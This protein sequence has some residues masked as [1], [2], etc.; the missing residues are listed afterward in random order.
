MNKSCCDIKNPLIRNGTSQP[1]RFNSALEPSSVKID[2][3]T[4]ADTI[5]FAYNYADLV[6]F[7]DRDNKSRST[8]HDFFALSDTVMLA[9]ISVTAY[10]S[11][12]TDMRVL[13]KN[14]NDKKTI[15]N[16][17]AI[18]KA[19]H[20]IA[21]EI[22]QW[23]SKIP[24]SSALYPIMALEI[25]KQLAGALKKLASFEKS[26]TIKNSYTL[27]FSHPWGDFDQATFD[28]LAA[29]AISGVDDLRQLFLSF[30]TSY[31]KLIHQS[32]I[33]LEKSLLVKNSHPPHIT[34]F[35]TFLH[36]LQHAKDHLNSFT[37]RHLDFY[38]KEVLRLQKREQVPDLVHVVFELAKNH[39]AYALPKGTALNAGKD[40]AG[41]PLTYKL[42]DE[43]VVNK[44]TVGSLQSVFVDTAD[45]YR[46]Y[47]AT[48]SNSAD[49]LGSAFD[50]S[51]DG[52]WKA[53]GDANLSQA[54]L[55]LAIA[56]PELYVKEGERTIQVEL[57]LFKSI[58]LKALGFTKNASGSYFKA[59]SALKDYF[60]VALSSEEAWLKVLPENLS[61]SVSG[62]G[63]KTI[64]FTVSL[65]SE[66]PSVVPFNSSHLDGGFETSWPVMKIELTSDQD[67]YAYGMLQ[68]NTIKTID[69][70][71]RAKGVRDL[72]IQNDFTLFAKDKAFQ[73]F[74]PNPTLGSNFYI[75]SSEVFSKKLSSCSI[76]FDWL[77]L[78]E[79]GSFE[80][81]YDVYNDVLDTKITNESFT[82]KVS[83]L[84][85]K[86]WVDIFSKDPSLFSV[87]SQEYDLL[88]YLRKVLKS[89]K[90]DKHQ[91]IKIIEGLFKKGLISDKETEELI[92]LIRKNYKSGSLNEIKDYLFKILEEKDLGDSK[93]V[94]EEKKEKDKEGHSSG[95]K[96]GSDLPEGR[97]RYLDEF[98][99]PELHEYVDEAELSNITTISFDSS[100]LSSYKRYEGILDI[101]NYNSATQRGFLQLK[102]SG[103]D[104][105]H[106]KYAEVY[107]KQAVTL[108]DDPDA[109]PAP[110]FPNAPYTPTINGIYLDYTSSETI[111]LQA[112]SSKADYEERVEQVFH[113]YPFGHKEIHHYL[114]GDSV[115]L[116]P[117]FTVD[118]TL[119]FGNFYIG[120]QEANPLESVSLLFQVYEGSGDPEKEVPEITW[121]YL[122]DNSWQPFSRSDII[123]DT[124][125][126]LLKSGVIKF[127]LPADI[128]DSNSLHDTASL[129]IRG[130][131]SKNVEALPDLI[132]VQAQVGIAQ[133]KENNNSVTHLASAL[134]AE[135]IGKLVNSAAGIKGVAQPYAS[136]EGKTVEKDNNF[137][138]RISE[139]LRHKNRAITL[140]DYERLILEEFPSI[141]RVKCISHSNMSTEIAP[142]YV[143]VVVI[144]D[145]RNKNAVNVLEPKVDV[146]T[147][148]DIK[149]FLSERSSLFVQGDDN[150]LLVVNP[151]FEQLKVTASV[152]VSA[153]D[154]QYYLKVLND[155]L[156]KF[157]APWAFDE[158]RDI[159]FGSSLHKSVILNFVE[160]RPYIDFISRISLTHYK[161]G[162]CLGMKNEIAT[163][164]ARSILTS[165]GLTDKDGFE[166][167]ITAYSEES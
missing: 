146:G 77:D 96:K 39:K 50:E 130:V 153:D 116:L 119:A 151:L 95:K 33:L 10:K 145:L 84:D 15:T 16:A 136:F 37:Q 62:V 76:V 105:M 134:P 36:L 143:M 17:R 110:E 89:N 26:L 124:T 30:F 111:D 73:P 86:Q 129:W 114:E 104:F 99:I 166:H 100:T 69:I 5:A 60:N 20:A 103:S 132:D 59:G 47:V 164:S 78:P 156:K 144:P 38:Y 72:I 122:V 157:L 107:T 165:Y 74:G 85:N 93:G 94:E 167:T 34:L 109:N 98:D 125:K 137:Y 154:T 27:F 88:Y 55:G 131:V 81:Y 92:K 158:G 66:D 6:K 14:Y 63:E 142:G 71:V 148:Q 68:G 140:W 141:H 120:L 160:K 128:S 155:D 3:H 40:D 75:G 82:V 52:N 23:N 53:F 64:S 21:G 112:N 162:S 138:R 42:T 118:K 133:F 163:T 117:Q 44:T 161:Q 108:A 13:L 7:Y 18:I 139:R 149:D 2:E 43:L 8:W 113:L 127:A 29:T 150:R 45:D 91:L 28:V 121:L 58:D 1:E 12:D 31:V 57:N 51:S 106:K 79:S 87:P 25:E 61:V 67:N 80:K 115:P 11:I 70:E 65:N 101:D 9:M 90:Y 48:Q 32:K 126:G 135:T 41:N 24:K 97:D 152:K 54:T 147:L 123:V 83:Y 19:I 46:V 4:I 49:G 102:L 56:S 22:Q 35:L 159:N